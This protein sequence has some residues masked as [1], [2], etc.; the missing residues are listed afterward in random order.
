MIAPHVEY[1]GF[2][3]LATA[4]EYRLRVH[5]AATAT[6]EV[7]IIIDNTAF[8]SKLVRY[9]DGPEVCFHRLQRE[10][11]AATGTM[12]ER[13]NVTDEDLEAYRVAH[14]PKASTRRKPQPP[15]PAS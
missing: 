5:Q 4:R 8:L 10:V 14:A 3:S 1:I 9:Q 2:K 6:L 11:A 12:P 15:P 13:L 7:T